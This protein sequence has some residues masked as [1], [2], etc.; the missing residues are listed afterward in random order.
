MVGALRDGEN[1]RCSFHGRITPHSDRMTGIVRDGKNVPFMP[2]KLIL[3]MDVESSFKE[4]ECSLHVEDDFVD[5]EGYFG[6]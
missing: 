1:H 2:L 6:F 3:L 5:K 4:N